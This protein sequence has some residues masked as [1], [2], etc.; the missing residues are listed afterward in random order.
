MRECFL[1]LCHVLLDGP[2][3][4]KYANNV[5]GHD[6]PQQSPVATAESAYEAL[7]DGLF[8]LLCHFGLLGNTALLVE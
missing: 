4:A 2:R 6:G 1:S 7:R 3:Y 5:F 8:I